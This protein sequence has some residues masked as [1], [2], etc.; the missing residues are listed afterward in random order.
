MALG[1]ASATVMSLTAC[2]Q[3]QRENP[4]L[5]ESEIAFGAP[6]FSKIQPEDYLPAFEVAIQQSRDEIKAITDNTDS[7][8]FE[9]TILAY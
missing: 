7:A 2:Q 5:Q 9:N 8:T 6:D 3:S 4:L 1:I